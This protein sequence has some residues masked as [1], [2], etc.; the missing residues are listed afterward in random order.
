MVQPESVLPGSAPL[1][2]AQLD[3]IQPEYV[4]RDP[5]LR[6]YLGSAVRPF[7]EFGYP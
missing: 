7:G 4:L 6:D 1:N 3:S 5:V 2:V